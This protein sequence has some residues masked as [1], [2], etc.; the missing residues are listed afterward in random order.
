MSILGVNLVNIAITLFAGRKAARVPKLRESDLSDWNEYPEIDLTIIR[1]LIDAVGIETF[2][3]MRAQFVADLRS[4]AQA[5][6]EAFARSDLAAASASAHAL[7]GA[8]ANIGLVRLSAIAGSFEQEAT[9]PGPSLD[10]ILDMSIASLN[11]A[12]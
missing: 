4:L 12:S 2:S 9:D 8:A 5:Y 11:D 7:K 10:T 3:S 6:H 1:A